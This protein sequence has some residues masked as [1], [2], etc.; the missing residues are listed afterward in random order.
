MSRLNLI[1][2]F[3]RKKIIQNML[4]YL[5]KVAKNGNNYVQLHYVFEGKKDLIHIFRAFGYI[6][7]QGD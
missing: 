5:L 6:S 4:Q 1:S 2:W 3:N 7:L